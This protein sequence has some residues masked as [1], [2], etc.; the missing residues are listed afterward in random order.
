MNH[1]FTMFVDMCLY[2]PNL[3]LESE[4]L[5]PFLENF[6]DTQDAVHR[7]IPPTSMLMEGQVFICPMSSRLGPEPHLQE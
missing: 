3:S 4:S 6:M 1:N 7:K 5:C 2:S